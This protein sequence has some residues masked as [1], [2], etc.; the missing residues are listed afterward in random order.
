MTKAFSRFRSVA[1]GAIA[2]LGLAALTLPAMAAS[3]EIGTLAFT[4]HPLPLY[5]GPGDN[6]PIRGELPGGLQIR[7]DGCRVLWCAVRAGRAHGW[8]FLYSL[9]FGQIQFTFQNM[10]QSGKSSPTTKYELWSFSPQTRS[11]SEAQRLGFYRAAMTRN[12]L[13][14]AGIAPANIFTQVRVTDPKAADGHMV[15]VVIKP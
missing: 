15:R 5:V 1:L 14:T 4:N 2:A 7:V 9:S 10:D 3:G 11:V 12:L 13:I 8:V 6:T